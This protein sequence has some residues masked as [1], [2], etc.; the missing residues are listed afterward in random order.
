MIIFLNDDRA[1]LSW[2]ARHRQGYVIDGRRKAKGGH[3]ALHRASCPVIRSGS[4]R[5]HWTTGAKLKACSLNQQE[6]ETWA[7]DE[8]GATLQP[9]ETCCPGDNHPSLNAPQTHVTRLGRDVLDYVLEAALVHMEQEC[10]SYRLTASEIADCLGK[11]PAQISPV[12]QQLI[13]E[14][15]L[16]VSG[17]IAGRRPIPPERIVLPTMSA[18]RTL[19]A[20]Q[21]D[22][23]RSIQN[24]L[25]KLG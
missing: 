23:D 14:G 5:L 6:L 3:F 25:A 19:E 15:F 10:P 12:L 1:Y 11:T 7:A 8:V 4:P 21:S 18:M 20:F 17:N 2:V 24:E 16:T 22:S 13:D 9:C